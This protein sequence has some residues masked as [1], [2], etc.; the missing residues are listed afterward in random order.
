MMRKPVIGSVSIW[1]TTLMLTAFLQGVVASAQ[2]VARFN[3]DGVTFAFSSQPPC[4]LDGAAVP[5]SRRGI[6][7][8]KDSVSISEILNWLVAEAR[9]RGSDVVFDV[10][11]N[12]AP[13]G[14]GV[15]SSASI[16]KCLQQSQESAALLQLDKTAVTRIRTARYCERYTLKLDRG[17]L[18][19]RTINASAPVLDRP[20]SPSDCSEAKEA[21]LL[22]SN[23]ATDLA[24]QG[25]C[26]FTP[27]WAIRFFGGAATDIW[28]LFSHGCGSKVIVA[29][30]DQD[31]RTAR[32]MSLSKSGIADF[33]HLR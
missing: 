18:G 11:I 4:T 21:I 9:D 17:P 1:S 24:L 5:V 13:P 7:G 27:D 8:F 30:P 14:F 10:R 6:G 28:I 3:R 2:E 32:Q 33:E 31:W 26:P 15:T 19:D 22:P 20:L 23:Y 16:G 12:S 29:G 25:S